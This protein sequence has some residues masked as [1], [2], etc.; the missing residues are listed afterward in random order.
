MHGSRPNARRTDG[1][2]TDG[3]TTDPARSRVAGDAMNQRCSPCRRRGT[4]WAMLSHRPERI[5][6]VPPAVRPQATLLL[7]RVR[8]CGGGVGAGSAW[9]SPRRS[10]GCPAG[11][12]RRSTGYRDLGRMQDSVW[13]IQQR[14]D[15]PV[16]GET[17]AASATPS[18][19]G[20]SPSPGAGDRRASRV[21]KNAGRFADAADGARA[22]ADC[23]GRV[24]GI[25][26]P[27]GTGPR[28]SDR[29]SH[30]SIA[31]MGASPAPAIGAS[32][33]RRR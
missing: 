22:T 12:P 8:V 28:S 9:C 19:S 25:G 6:G 18:M 15:G 13:I 30:G 21:R 23:P 24:T 10:S 4:G 20:H 29:G 32:A 26:H 2:R 16:A 11:P 27:Q 31:V 7:P 17:A 14:R 3:R 33:S 1:R 5:S